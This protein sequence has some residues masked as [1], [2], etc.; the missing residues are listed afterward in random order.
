LQPGPRLLVGHET[1]ALL[2][3]NGFKLLAQSS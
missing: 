2:R 1:A 3:G